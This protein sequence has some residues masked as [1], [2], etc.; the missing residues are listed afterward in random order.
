M[1]GLQPNTLYYY[2]MVYRRQGG[3]DWTARAEHTF[4][5][6]RPPGESFTFTVVSDSHMNIAAGVAVNSQLYQTALRSIAGDNPDFHLDLGDTF[7]MDNVSTQ[8]NANNAYL[9]TR[10]FLGLISPSVPIFIVLGNHEQQEGWHLRDSPD[11]AR[12]PAVLSVN[13][14][15][16]YYPNPNPS[17]GSFYTG[18][19]NNNGFGSQAI[20]GDH[21]L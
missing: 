13:A 12:T 10:S 4:H 6:Q 5:T 16:R 14:R 18:D 21:L 15:K 3:S 7:A 17:L 20:S 9:A 11:P 19:K 1:Q 2:R 8:E